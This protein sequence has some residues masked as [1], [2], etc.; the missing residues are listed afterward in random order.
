MRDTF[1][2][3]RRMRKRV[4]PVL[5]ITGFSLWRRHRLHAECRC[6]IR[7]IGLGLGAVA[8]FIVVRA[9]PRDQKRLA[10]CAADKCVNAN[11]SAYL[12]TRPSDVRR[13][14]AAVQHSGS[15]DGG[16]IGLQNICTLAGCCWRLCSRGETRER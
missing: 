16:R 7:A 4:L 5:C 9:R 15:N 13:V 6:C 11:I 8:T 10:T 2:D 12:T 3:G 14:L 1:D